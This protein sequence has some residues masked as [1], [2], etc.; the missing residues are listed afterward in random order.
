[1]DYPSPMQ[2]YRGLESDLDEKFASVGDMMYV[3]KFEY[4]YIPIGINFSN[5]LNKGWFIAVKGEYDWFLEGSGRYKLMNSSSGGT[6]YKTHLDQKSG[7]G[8]RGSVEL[9][10]KVNR[11]LSFAV[12]PFVR[13]W[14]IAESESADVYYYRGIKVGEP[15]EPE[16]HTTETGINLIL[17]VQLP[18]SD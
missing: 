3:K 17:R 14:K 10:K 16:N 4:H 5:N 2:S 1:M 8:L 18:P 11:V 7:Y 9:Q 6:L 13:Y 12:E 15:R